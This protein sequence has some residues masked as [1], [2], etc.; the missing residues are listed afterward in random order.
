VRPLEP[1]RFPPPS[2]AGADGGS[3]SFHLFGADS[4]K[5]Q[6]IKQERAERTQKIANLKTEISLNGVLRPRI[7]ALLDSLRTQPAKE[8]LASYSSL[9]SQ[10]KND[11]SPAK[12]ETNAPN[13]PTYDVM[14]LHLL[15]QVSTEA[16]EQ[17]KS[18]DEQDKIVERL[19]ER[20]AF[21]NGQLDDR[22]AECERT[23]GELEEEAKR[24]ITSDD[25]HEGFSSGVR[26]DR[27][28]SSPPR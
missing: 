16:K 25:I 5:Q 20:L 23:I 11:P 24:K 2:A 6:Q 22:T 17:S 12:P 1:V 8:A 18:G 3:P 10:L 21:H 28:S 14:L 9:V 27:P 13:Q 15:E 26:L 7:L 19:A 4:W